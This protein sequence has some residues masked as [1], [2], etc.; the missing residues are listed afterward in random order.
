MNPEARYTVATYYWDKAYRDFTIG[1]VEKRQM[2]MKGLEWVERAIGLKP[3]YVEALVYKNLLL[4]LQANLEPDPL[5]QD[6]LIREA[7]DTR[8]Y[9]QQ[10]RRRPR[11][12]Q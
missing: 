7:D 3:D 9:A 4:R 2:V 12:K 6:R 1:A 10:L 5:K 8:D 11:Q